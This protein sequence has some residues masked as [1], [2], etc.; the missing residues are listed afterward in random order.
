MAQAK[1][2][3]A[4]IALR[5]MTGYMNTSQEPPAASYYARS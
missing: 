1:E 4:E 5:Q 3:S 2:D